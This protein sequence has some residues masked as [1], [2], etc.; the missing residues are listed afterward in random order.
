MDILLKLEE[1]SRLRQALSSLTD[2]QREIIISYYIE[3]LFIIH[4]SQRL[5]I[6]YRTVVNIK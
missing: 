1:Q 3:R 4:I 6:I 5:G 2:R